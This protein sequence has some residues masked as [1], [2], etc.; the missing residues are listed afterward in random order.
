MRSSLSLPPQASL[1]SQCLLSGVS[2]DH[3]SSHSGTCL[4]SVRS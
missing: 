1:A 4:P 3:A 2:R